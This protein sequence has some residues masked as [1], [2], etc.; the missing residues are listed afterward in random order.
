MLDDQQSRIDRA[1]PA[2]SLSK[3]SPVL[4]CS[5]CLHH[6][7]SKSSLCD[8]SSLCDFVNLQK[9]QGCRNQRFRPSQADRADPPPLCPNLTMCLCFRCVYMMEA[10]H[11]RRVTHLHLVTLSISRNMAQCCNQQNIQHR[12]DRADPAASLSKS[13]PVLV[14][15][16]FT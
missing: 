12:A 13:S 1:D 5:L 15:A 16:M 9:R 3:P 7:R 14:F 2:A 4:M 8:V 6:G 10:Q 11:P